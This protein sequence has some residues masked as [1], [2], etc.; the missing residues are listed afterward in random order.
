MSCHVCHY[1]LQ[2]F[3]KLNSKGHYMKQDTHIGVH[4]IACITVIIWGT[5]FVWTKLLIA[6]GISPAQI[7]TL[8]FVI[9][10]VLMLGFSLINRRGGVGHRWFA[11][12]WRDEFRMLLLGI[13]GGSVYFLAENEA[14][15]FTTA[16]N[17]SLIVC[18]CPLFTMLIHRICYRSTPL[19]LS[20]IGGSMVAFL[21]MAVVVLNGHFVLHLSPVGDVL[22][23][24]AC[25]SWACYSLLMKDL[26]LRYPALFI[27][28]KVFFYGLLTVLPYYLL[29]PGWPSWSVLMR[30]DVACNLLFLGCVASMLCFLIWNWCIRRLGAVRATNWVYL[31]PL[32]TVASASLVLG[33]SITPYFVIGSVL[34]LVGLIWSEK[35]SPKES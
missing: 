6:A 33:E 24:V 8:R 31:N 27:T 9:A 30:P 34:I 7:F 20:Q 1:V 17:V 18:S 35:F 29:V 15:R 14:L 16:S 12:S 11:S 5:T 26:S 25:L 10:Y 21:G 32:A 13:T 3:V 19:R 28:R 4:L 2:E 22:A 23:F